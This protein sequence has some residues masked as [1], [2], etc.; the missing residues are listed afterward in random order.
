MSLDRFF[1][2]PDAWEE[3]SVTLSGDESHHCLRVMRKGL[4]DELEI[5]DGRGRWG[6]GVV[7]SDEDGRV[8]VELR[9]DGSGERPMPA[10][11]LTLAIPKGKTMDLIVQKAV[12]LGV[13]AI[14][15]VVSERGVVRIEGAEAEKKRGK[16][17]RV[18]LEACKPCGQNVLPAVHAPVLFETWLA[19]RSA[20]RCG[21]LAT[22]TEGAVP[23]REAIGHLPA[24]LEDLDLV[25]GPEGDFSATETARAVQKGIE[26]VSLGDITLRV[27]TA[28]LFALSVLN[29]TS[30][31]YIFGISFPVRYTCLSSAVF[32]SDDHT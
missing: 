28:V 11:T 25:I 13:G 30:R 7:A 12:E 24:G 1:V 22:L 21:M 27:E 32:F 6:R 26:P 17:Q 23:I 9:E 18:A 10:I 5:F 2:S 20:D 3:R 31:R 19:A 14:Q 29:Y 16:W 8:R 4:G 15:P